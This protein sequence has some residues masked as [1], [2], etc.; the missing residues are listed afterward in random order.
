[1]SDDDVLAC[2]TLAAYYDQ[3]LSEAVS[4]RTRL[5][6]RRN[7]FMKKRSL[8]II[9]A[10]ALV[11]LG[12]YVFSNASSGQS[13]SD[14]GSYSYSN[15]SNGQSQS[16]S[17]SGNTIQYYLRDAGGIEWVVIPPEQLSSSQ[18]AWWE[19]PAGVEFYSN[20]TASIAGQWEAL[21]PTLVAF[22]PSST[23]SYSPD[24]NYNVSAMHAETMY[25]QENQSVEDAP[26][27]AQPGAI[28]ACSLNDCVDPS[29]ISGDSD[30]SE[31]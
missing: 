8:I 25:M 1:V 22:I 9:V 24:S 13:Q 19:Y 29:T 10:V 3:Q 26:D 16:S 21:S 7:T 12:I 5:A 27:Y 30:T 11:V 17:G 6:R 20:G 18:T 15:D 31:P 2:T 14:T 4:L 28:D 23:P